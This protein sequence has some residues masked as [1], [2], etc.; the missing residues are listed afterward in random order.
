MITSLHPIAFE[1]DVSKP[2]AGPQE[3]LKIQGS[4]SNPKKFQG[5][6]FA[7]FPTKIWDG[8]Q[9]SHQPPPPSGF[10]RPFTAIPCDVPHPLVFASISLA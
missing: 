3:G 4:S 6:S 7:V 2:T 1:W 8:G 9:K 5:Q 10:R